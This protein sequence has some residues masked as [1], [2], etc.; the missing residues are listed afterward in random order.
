V[1]LFD[2]DGAEEGGNLVGL[3]V[4]RG[5]A[6]RFVTLARAGKVDGDAAEVLGVGL[7][8]ERPAGVVSRRVRDPQKR[9]ALPCTS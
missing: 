9:L 7:Q 5:R 2:P 3:A 4:G 1:G 8:L 6:G